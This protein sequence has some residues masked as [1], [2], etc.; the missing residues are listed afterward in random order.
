M[1]IL[2]LSP[3]PYLKENDTAG[4]HDLNRIWTSVA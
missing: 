3:Q 2:T 4:D 1:Y